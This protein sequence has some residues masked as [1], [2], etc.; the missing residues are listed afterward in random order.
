MKKEEPARITRI[1]SRS[2]EKFIIKEKL[3]FSQRY[4]IPVT[5]LPPAFTS[6]GVF[7]CFRH[8][9]WIPWVLVA[10]YD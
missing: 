2:A 8:D 7:V 10:L 9:E 6:R 4:A 5:A 1:N 3:D